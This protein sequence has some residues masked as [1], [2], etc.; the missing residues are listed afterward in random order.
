SENVEAVVEQHTYQ[1]VDNIEVSVISSERENV[2]DISPGLYVSLL[3]ALV[4]VI[5]GTSLG[6]SFIG[7]AAVMITVVLSILIGLIPL[8][9]LGV[10]LNQISVIGLII[11]LGIL[12]DDSIVVNDNIERRLVAG[13][14]RLDA[15]YNGVREVA[16]SA[17]A[18]T[19][20]IVLAFSPLLFLSGAN[21]EFISALPS[22]LITTMIVSTVLTLFLVHVHLYL[23]SPQ[24]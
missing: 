22:I 19:I 15:M 5:I 17:I 9:W 24:N 7:S 20:A 18:S 13:D 11:A 16:P 8:P 21:G 3:I 23:V 6:L 2:E 4:A 12:V 10:D 14:S 1:F